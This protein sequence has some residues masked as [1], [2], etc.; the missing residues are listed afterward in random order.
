M[1]VSARRRL[2][3]L[4]NGWISIAGRK[5]CPHASYA[6]AFIMEAASWCVGTLGTHWELLVETP[7]TDVWGPNN[8][9]FSAYNVHIYS[10]LQ[11]PLVKA[12]ACWGISLPW[13]HSTIILPAHS[14]MQRSTERYDSPYGPSIQQ[15]QP[16]YGLTQCYIPVFDSHIGTLEFFVVTFAQLIGA[17]QST[18]FI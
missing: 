1:C 4:L 6:N 9:T 7:D 12:V 2:D 3:L 17:A 14:M 13:A 5:P 16:L 15:F 18:P 11:P 10:W 8:T